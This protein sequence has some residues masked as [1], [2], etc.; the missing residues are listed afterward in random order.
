M[1]GIVTAIVVLVVAVWAGRQFFKTT[2]ASEVKE[3][4]YGPFVIKMERFT[5]SSFNMNY[6]KSVEHQHIAYSVWHNGKV[7]EYPA[8]LQN[9]TG[10]SHLWRVYILK[11]APQPTLIAGSQSVFLISAK[12]K[13]Y[14][15][16]SLEAQTSDFTK[17][18]WLDAKE[19]QPGE[20]FEL[21]M[22]DGNTSMEHPDTLEGGNYLMINQ[23][24]VLF[25]PTMD[26]FHF[27]KDSN[28]I[29]NYDKD[30][31]ALAF[32]P[33]QKTIVFPGHFQTWNSNET[34]EFG[35]A[36]ITYDFRKDKKRVLPYS[37]NET[38]LYRPENLN[39]D[40]FKTYFNWDTSGQE[41]ILQYIK[42]PK[43]AL[44]QGYFKESAFYLYPT[45]TEMVFVF[46]QFLLDYLKWSPETVLTEKYHEYTG[47]V[48]QIGRTKPLFYLVGKEDEVHLMPDIY[49]ETDESTPALIRQIGEAF[50][51]AL[52]TGR[53]QEYFTA[54]P[55]NETY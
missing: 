51:A 45:N 38:R 35:N 24:L 32:S 7:V 42:P 49:S 46:K 23:K 14:E 26:Q 37:K 50:N 4:N 19:G 31:N 1:T 43:P 34:P 15:V 54:I 39:L 10:F 12:E 17:F 5:S 11:N 53:Y 27:N 25:V 52:M 48:F 8:A 6:G 55:E 21:F 20:A 41:T 9:N 13:E 18:Q 29:D 16:K 33:D 22:A 30:G 2:T 28:F 40:W 3:F 47:R 36:L 44:W